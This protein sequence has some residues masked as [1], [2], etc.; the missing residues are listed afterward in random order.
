VNSLTPIFIWGGIVAVAFGYLWWQGYVARL[1]VFF[2]ETWNELK[3]GRCSWPTWAELQGSTVLIA[4]VI[5]LLGVF[6]TV[7][8]L[9][10]NKFLIKVL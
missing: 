4:V 8:D 9:L 10:F 7:V 6:V 3:P 2:R 5:G 1:A